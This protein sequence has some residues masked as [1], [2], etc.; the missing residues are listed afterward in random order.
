MDFIPNKK[1]RHH[2][3]YEGQ[4]A[5]NAE[6]ARRFVL[7]YGPQSTS[8]SYKI[9]KTPPKNMKF[10]VSSTFTD[11][12]REREILMGEASQKLRPLAMNHGIE[13]I[14]VDMR[15]G[16]RDENTRDHRTWMECSRIIEMCREESCGTFFVSL[17][18]EK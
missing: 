12:T 8:Y 5:C 15:W 18:S 1:Q 3:F 14:V 6:K 9:W 10:I 17:Q 11:T 4:N 13:V 7:K 2:K 16:L